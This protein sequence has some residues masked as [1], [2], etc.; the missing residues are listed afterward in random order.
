MASGNRLINKEALN[1]PPNGSRI[2]DL[3]DTGWTI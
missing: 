1:G 2:Y 3:T